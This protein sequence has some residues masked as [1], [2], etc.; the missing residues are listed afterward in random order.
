METKDV[1]KKI[2]H[3]YDN[4]C[5]MVRNCLQIYPTAASNLFLNQQGKWVALS[6][7]QPIPVILT[8]SD[9]G[10]GSNYYHNPLLGV[11][12]V[13]ILLVFVDKGVLPTANYIFN[14]STAKI[15]FGSV[16]TYRDPIMILYQ[17]L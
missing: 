1:I 11:G 17:I 9:V 12:G 6:T 10:Q 5:C 3:L 7:P 2:N 8:I 14:A 13:S 16:Y 15:E 4:F